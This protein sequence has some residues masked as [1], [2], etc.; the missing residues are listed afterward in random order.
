MPKATRRRSIQVRQRNRLV[1]GVVLGTVL[2]CFG[3]GSGASLAAPPQV[4]IH[5]HV[6]DHTGPGYVADVKVPIEWLRDLKPAAASNGSPNTGAASPST[7]AD[8]DATGP[9]SSGPASSSGGGSQPNA[10]GGSSSASPGS[11][12][13]APNEAAGGSALPNTIQGLP[14]AQAGAWIYSAFKDLPAGQEAEVLRTRESGA[15][16]DLKA[17]SA[18]ADSAPTAKSL[19]V[20]VSGVKGMSDLDLSVPVQVIGTLQGLFVQLLRLCDRC[21]WDQ[22]QP[23]SIVAHLGELGSYAPFSIVRVQGGGENIVVETLAR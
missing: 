17:V 9:A 8:G 11:A 12:T 14:L 1:V 4:W 7:P 20:A 21:P 18:A 3:A 13:S 19:R 5:A 16:M 6:V 10:A 15:D 2:A 23:S 22:I